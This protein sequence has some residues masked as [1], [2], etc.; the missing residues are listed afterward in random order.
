MTNIIYLI[1]M[2]MLMKNSKIYILYR[3]LMVGGNK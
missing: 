3:E 2:K 1:V